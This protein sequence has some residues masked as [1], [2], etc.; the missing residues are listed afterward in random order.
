M[1]PLA[2]YVFSGLPPSFIGT[3]FQNDT[4]RRQVEA[5]VMAMDSNLAPIVGQQITLDNTNASVA[6]PRISLLIARANAAYPVL[7]YPGA[8]ECDLIVRG[9]PTRVGPPLSQVPRVPY[10]PTPAWEPPLH[11]RVSSACERARRRLASCASRRTRSARRS[12]CSD[13]AWCAS[14]TAAGS[15]A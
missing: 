2:L 6:G 8:R 15:R 13:S 10:P 9:G 3:G 14:S 5:F 12:A 4:Q 7:G 11:I 1:R